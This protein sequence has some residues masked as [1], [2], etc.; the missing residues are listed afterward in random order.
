MENKKC[1]HH[2]LFSSVQGTYKSCRKK[3][4]QKFTEEILKKLVKFNIFGAQEHSR[5]IFEK[6][7]PFILRKAVLLPLLKFN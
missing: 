3:F 7:S 6:G 2:K 1:V 4:C 5:A